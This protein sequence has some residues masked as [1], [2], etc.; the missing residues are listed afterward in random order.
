MK[1]KDTASG[2]D[3]QALLQLRFFESI[4][5]DHPE[6]E[7]LGSILMEI[8]H[9]SQDSIYRRMRGETALTFGE[10]A[11]V[12]DYFKVSLDGFLGLSIDQATVGFRFYRLNSGSYHEYLKF[13]MDEFQQTEIGIEQHI[14]YS[15]KDIPVFYFFLFPEL[16]VFKAFFFGK[17]L[18]TNDLFKNEQFD[19]E[20]IY[21]LM[22]APRA[23]LE[24]IG[25]SLA[26]SYLQIPGTEIWNHSTINGH[27][28][29]IRYLWE[30]GQFSSKQSALSILDCTEKLLRHVESQAEEGTKFL[31]P[32][33]KEVGASCELYF[34]EGIHLE[35]AILTIKAEQLKCYVLHNTGDY[36]ITTDSA[37]CNR[38]DEYFK[39]VL[40]KSGLIS[41][42]GAKDRQRLFRNYGGKIE[43]LRKLIEGSA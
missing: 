37:F 24:Q 32:D 5:N 3:D 40:S 2:L 36:L 14:T 16:A 28:Y 43:K 29:Q 33:N 26:K 7:S 15:A 12:A 30:A 4:K 31:A 11:K 13:I 27:L 35:N 21:E 41:K 20:K 38:T 23:V 8:L 6:G 9:L 39:N 18:W 34:S 25:L 22:G 10:L 42:V 1:A 19:F 17:I